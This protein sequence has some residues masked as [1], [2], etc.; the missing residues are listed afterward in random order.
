MSD[1]CWYTRLSEVTTSVV[2]HELSSSSFCIIGQSVSYCVDLLELQ[3]LI[4]TS[5]SDVLEDASPFG[6]IFCTL[7]VLKKRKK[8]RGGGAPL[9][10]LHAAAGH[11][12]MQNPHATR[13][14]IAT[15]SCK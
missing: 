15:P 10:F 3:G 1:T 4:G 9:S 14:K 12:A 5:C 8:P 13:T 6:S 11:R 7:K 2:C